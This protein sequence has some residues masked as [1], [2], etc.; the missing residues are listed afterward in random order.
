M[1]I[2]KIIA[3]LIAFALLTASLCSCGYELVLRKK[4]E[5]ENTTALSTDVFGNTPVTDAQGNSNPSS[6][7]NPG[8]SE[9]NQEETTGNSEEEDFVGSSFHAL[10]MSS[11]DVL[12][13][14][15]RA[16]NDVK[17]RAPGYLRYE[18]QETSDVEAGDGHIQFM[19]NILNLVATELLKDSGDEEAT[20]RINAHD[21]IAVRKTFPLYNKD[22]GC[23][24]TTMSIIKSA[25]C[26][27]D[28]E[29]MRVVIQFDDQ[30]NPHHET[31]DFAKIMT[32][33]NREALSDPIEEYLVVLDKNQY[34]FSINY[35]GCEITCIID[36]E[37]GRM[38]SLTQKMI[39]D[40]DINMNL[41]LFIFQTSGVKASGRI[42]NILKYSDFDWS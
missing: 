9:N 33:I 11:Q 16:M 41:D 32:P 7:S 8:Y 18:Y 39:M 26:Y 28:G 23:E 5:D 30:L 42:V 15:R 6:G 35:T 12:E 3:V 25:V 19:N 17:V 29:T 14:Y 37:S 34:E 40:I 1:K 21:D 2:R 22:V 36:I 31:S 4:G 27:S 13:L 20:I 38:I 10:P 24:L